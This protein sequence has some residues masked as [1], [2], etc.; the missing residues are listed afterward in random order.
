MN[1]NEFKRIVKKNTYQLLIFTSRASL[2]AIG[3]S[4]TW[5]V[6]NKK[7]KMSRWELLFRKEKNTRRW[8]H[9]YLNHFRA[10]VGVEIIPFYG[11]YFWKSKLLA[12]IEWKS[13]EQLIKTIENSK[14]TYPYKNIY[15]FIGPNCNTYVQYILNKHPKIKIKLPWNALG[16]GWKQ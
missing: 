2:P 4:H 13:A 8:G 7:G 11:H 15:H 3:I 16:K 12:K 5:L 1:N 9:L 6:T 14:K 10:T